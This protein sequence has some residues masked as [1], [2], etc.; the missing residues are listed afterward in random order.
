MSEERLQNGKSEQN[1][2]T[3]LLRYVEASGSDVAHYVLS[4]PSGRWNRRL[5]LD[6]PE[7]R[8]LIKETAS[9][10]VN[11]IQADEI[12]GLADRVQEAFEKRGVAI[13]GEPKSTLEKFNEMLSVALQIE[14]KYTGIKVQG[15]IQENID[16]LTS[17]VSANREDF[18]DLPDP[19]KEALKVLS[20][21]TVV[22]S[23]KRYVDLEA[24][25]AAKRMAEIDRI[26]TTRG[27]ERLKLRIIAAG[28]TVGG[29]VGAITEDLLGGVGEGAKKLGPGL[30]E[31][32]IVPLS[33]TAKGLVDKTIEVTEKL[34]EAAGKGIGGMLGG[35][36]GK[37]I[38]EFKKQKGDPEH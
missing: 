20:Q 2:K 3:A 8:S 14:E 29:L 23:L 11:A 18:D 12:L 36:V 19:T 17:K 13:E 6:S 4:S 7:V 21:A 34:P 5:E 1:H 16:Y 28:H 32:I 26:L 30:K 38:G 27:M 15:L 33:E 25:E 9:A 31:G 37:A 10:A 22:A 24:V 35:G